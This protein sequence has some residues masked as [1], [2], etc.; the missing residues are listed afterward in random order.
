MHTI[1][2]ERDTGM[3]KRKVTEEQREAYFYATCWLRLKEA[4]IETKKKDTSAE[5]VNQ[6]TKF[7][8]L[9]DDTENILLYTLIDV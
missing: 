3:F 9:M 7:L 8:K 2:L 1:G 6:A 5:N 4:M